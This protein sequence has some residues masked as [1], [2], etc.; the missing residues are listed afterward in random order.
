MPF[1]NIQIENKENLYVGDTG[2]IKIEGVGDNIEHIDIHYDG[3][4]PMYIYNHENLKNHL[5]LL[6]VIII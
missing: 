2:K 6:M 1:D 5:I 4:S 3:R